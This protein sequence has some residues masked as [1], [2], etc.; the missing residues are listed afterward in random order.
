MR[1]YKVGIIGSG[2]ISRTYIGD[3]QRFYPQLEVAACSDRHLDRAERLAAEFGVANAEAN[4]LKL[5]QRGVYGDGGGEYNYLD[6][7]ELNCIIELLESY[8]K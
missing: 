5:C 2:N 8:P 7:P 1:R 3:I 4:G 6:A